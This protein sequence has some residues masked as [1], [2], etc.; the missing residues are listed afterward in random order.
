METSDPERIILDSSVW[1]AFLHDTDSQH[2]R[3]L[4]LLAQLDDDIIVPEYVVVEVATILK[5]KKKTDEAKR[6]VHRILN[7]KIQSFLP[8]DAL[9]R[10]AATLFCGRTDTLS[11]TDTAL[12][13]LSERYHVITFDMHLQKAIN[14]AR[15]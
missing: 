14:K 1:V 12:L 4:T 6:F 13:V 3:A 10:E 9:V 15:A 7:E 11:F 8:A 2:G 5:R